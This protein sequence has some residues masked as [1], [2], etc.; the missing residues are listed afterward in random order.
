MDRV[1]II[2]F[3]YFGLVA[4]ILWGKQ[5]AL[6]SKIYSPHDILIDANFQGTKLGSNYYDFSIIDYHRFLTQKKPFILFFYENNCLSCIKQDVL[7]RTITSTEVPFIKVGF[8][9]QETVLQ[10]IEL[11]KLYR[12]KNVPTLLAINRDSNP[13][14]RLEGEQ[15]ELE[16]VRLIEK[17][18]HK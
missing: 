11:S 15:N 2:F 7:L 14:M 5:S 16:I 3:V 6:S 17:S 9:A 13:V 8:H 1:I 10:G 12:V 18:K 4:A